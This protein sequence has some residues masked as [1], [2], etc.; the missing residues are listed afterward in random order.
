MKKILLVED[1]ELNRDMLGRRLKRRG[2]EVVIAIDGQE[3]V[4]KAQSENPDLVLMDMSLPVMDGWTAT[5]VLKKNPETAT[6]PVIALTAHAM[7]GDRD[8]AMQAGCDDY[9]TKPVDIRR[10]LEKIETLLSNASTSQSQESLTSSPSIDTALAQPASTISVQPAPITTPAPTPALHQNLT[11][12]SETAPPQSAQPNSPP[13]S[14]PKSQPKPQQIVSSPL[15]VAPS[16]QPAANREVGSG[17]QAFPDPKTAG[18]I[19]VVDDIEENRDMLGRRLIRKGYD[20]V[21]ADS[22]EAALALLGE[23]EVSLVLLDIMMPGIGG[24]ETLRQIRQRYSQL[25]MPVIMV[26]AKDQS[27]DIVQAFDLGA[28]DYVTKPLELSVLLVRI[29]SQLKTI[30]LSHSVSVPTPEP[31]AEKKE[32]EFTERYR[33][34]KVL[35]ETAISQTFTAQDVQN[36]EDPLKL[37]QKIQLQ[38][39]DPQ[40]LS[41]A[42]EIFLAEFKKFSSINKYE[43][44]LLPIDAFEQ[45]GCFYLISDY[46][47]GTLLSDSTSEMPKGDV[48]KLVKGTEEIL[49]IIEFLHYY[50]IFH[51]QLDASCF[52]APN[53]RG[54]NLVLID[55]GLKNRLILK[56]QTIYPADQFLPPNS[57]AIDVT[58]SSSEEASVQADIRS[59]GMIAMHALTGKSEPQACEN[60]LLDE[61]EWSSYDSVNREL[62]AFLKK[63]LC[64]GADGV[65]TTISAASRD[66]LKLWFNLSYGDRISE[67]SER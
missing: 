33:P 39:S 5:S 63:M 57:Q 34:I 43:K 35:S 59:I 31:V 47:E 3:G 22:G 29:A 20:V 67:L 50:E 62:I 9:D 60:F 64:R 45:D 41:T 16:P 11:T 54:G 37:V 18:K 42:K 36:S 12:I 21:L 24:I 49:R 14:E 4:T 1:N 46:I 23:S 8:K 48:R 52:M 17:S 44:I 10:L 19:L 61:S 28:N 6:V 32:P 65:Y 51:Y 38:I 30:K 55:L 26:T 13:L 53:K 58:D 56:L 7:V 15:P 66:I 25:E 2:Y 27:E 40:I